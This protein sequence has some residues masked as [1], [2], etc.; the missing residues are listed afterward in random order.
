MEEKAREEMIEQKGNNIFFDVLLPLVGYGS[1]AFFLVAFFKASYH[2]VHHTQKVFNPFQKVHVNRDILQFLLSNQ[3]GHQSGL[4]AFFLYLGG[5]GL[6]IY[7][8]TA[9]RFFWKNTSLLGKI[10]LVL[11]SVLAL[12]WL[13]LHS[14]VWIFHHYGDGRPHPLVGNLLF[15]TYAENTGMAWSLLEGKTGFLS[16]MSLVAI[17]A[18]LYFF[19]VSRDSKVMVTALILILAGALGN[20]HDRV[21]YGYVRDFVDLRYWPIFNLADAYIVVGAVLIVLYSFLEGRGEKEGEEK[22]E[23][24]S[25]GGSEL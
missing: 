15:M 5:I 6:L 14:K 23:E 8:V 16:L 22:K 21:W 12:T 13:D 1:L 4:F 10:Y 17:I 11:F 24:V 2:I 9:L 25:G 19:W 18:V 20:L 3:G 7:L